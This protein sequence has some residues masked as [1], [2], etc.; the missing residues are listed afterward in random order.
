LWSIFLYKDFFVEKTIDAL[1][2]F[3]CIQKRKPM[4]IKIEEDVLEELNLND[5]LAVERTNLA[6]ER[7]FLAYFRTSV[8]FASAGFTIIRVAALE[9]IEELG[10]LLLWVAPLI[11]V[12]GIWRYIAV[13][14]KVRKQYFRLVERIR[15]AKHKGGNL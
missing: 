2:R 13:Y 15:K 10:L 6:V 4:R 14:R 3:Y 5:A 9:Q 8:V 11:L 1:R 12:V 7:T